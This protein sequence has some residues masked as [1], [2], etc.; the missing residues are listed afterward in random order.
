MAEPGYH[1]VEKS[2]V[3]QIP[4]HRLATGFPKILNAMI[5]GFNIMEPS[6]AISK[7]QMRKNWPIRNTMIQADGRPAAPAACKHNTIAIKVREGH[8]FCKAVTA[9]KDYGLGA[10]KCQKAIRK[11]FVP[12]N[13][14]L[15]SHTEISYSEE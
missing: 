5:C 4:A 15:M 6:R 9:A 14:H 12:I 8:F 7:I 3:L 11:Y 1:L 10:V 2:L 13:L